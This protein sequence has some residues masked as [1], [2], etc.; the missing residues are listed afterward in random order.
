MIVTANGKARDVARGTTLLEFLTRREL[1]AERIVVEY[2][3]E[4]LRRDRFARTVLQEGD[5]LE[6]VQMV[7]GG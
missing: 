4:P 5:T 3:G 1:C 7:G 6:I 2:N